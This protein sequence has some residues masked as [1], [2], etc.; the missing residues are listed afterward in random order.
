MDKVDLTGSTVVVTGA[1][2][3]IG[4]ETARELARRGKTGRPTR[5]GEMCLTHR[6]GR[7]SE[8]IG[9]FCWCPNSCIVFTVSR[10]LL[11][12]LFPAKRVKIIL[13]MTFSHTSTRYS[14]IGQ[15]PPGLNP[16]YNIPD[17]IPRHNP[18][19]F[20]LGHNSQDALLSK[21]H[22]AAHPF[23][24]AHQS[25]CEPSRSLVH[26]PSARPSIRPFRQSTNTFVRPFVC[27]HVC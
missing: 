12:I 17:I 3:G 26:L 11:F 5:S 4:K 2:S 25:V 21:T 22:P 23:T 20:W 8:R 16:G 6:D 15:N 10:G 14:G 9:W 1:N 7:T 18:F 19:W 24:R 27:P 13:M